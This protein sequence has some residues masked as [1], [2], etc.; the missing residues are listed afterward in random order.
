[1]AEIIYKE[2]FYAIVGAAMKVHSKLGRGLNEVIY[3]EAMS[4]ECERSHIPFV[5][6]KEVCLY[7]DGIPLNKKYRL[8]FLCYDKIIVE[9]KSVNALN[10]FHRAQLINYMRVTGIKAGLL[11]NF[12][13]KSLEHENYII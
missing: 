6:E 2:E 8:D 3:Q 13:S 11:L 12:G 9:L 10:D 5:R 7:Y 4:I 1:M